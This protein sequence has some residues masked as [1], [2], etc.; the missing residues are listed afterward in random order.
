[1]KTGLSTRV[2]LTPSY[3][4]FC[5]FE[6]VAINGVGCGSLVLQDQLA[7]SCPY[8]G[9]YEFWFAP[10]IPISE[11]DHLMCFMIA[12]WLFVAGVLQGVI[13]FDEKVPIRTKLTALYAFAGCDVAWIV[14]M[15]VYTKYFS[16]YH[17]VG[18]VF[19]IYQRTRFWIPGRVS[20]FVEVDVPSCTNK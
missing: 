18:S 1:M 12:G 5:T 13:N 16:I 11:L 3:S 8:P 14:L 9:L 20:P 6:T 17:I 4:A 7:A 10:P 19:T 2:R 15:V